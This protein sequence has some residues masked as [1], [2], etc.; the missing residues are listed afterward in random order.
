MFIGV[1]SICLN[2]INFC[3]VLLIQRPD[4]KVILMSATLN[5]AAFSKYYNDCPS[6][7]IPGFTYPVEELY[8]EDIYTLNRYVKILYHYS[9]L[10]KNHFIYLLNYCC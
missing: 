4:I 8:L 7:N 1:H 10:I 9:L 6:L 5:A 3:F 2:F